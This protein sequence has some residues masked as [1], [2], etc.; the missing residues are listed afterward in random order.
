MSSIDNCLCGNTKIL[1][2]SFNQC[3]SGRSA[4]AGRSDLSIQ[5]PIDGVPK[6]L[7]LV[8]EVM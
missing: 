2:D 7:C 3:W 1:I 4:E 5:K 6:T 8:F